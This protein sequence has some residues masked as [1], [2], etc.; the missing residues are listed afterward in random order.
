MAVI[1]HTTAR[2]PRNLA[3]RMGR[4]S[5]GHRKLAV[6]GWLAFV[7]AALVLGGAVGHEDP[8]RCG[9]AARRGRESG[10][11]LRR[12]GAR[13]RRLG[14][15]SRPEPDAARGRSDLRRH[16]SRRG[17]DDRS[18][19]GRGRP[20][21]PVCRGPRPHLRRR[22]F[23][24]DRLRPG[25]AA[26][27]PR[28][29]NQRRVDGR[30]RRPRGAQAPRL[31]RGR[32]RRSQRRPGDRGHERARL[33]PRGAALDPALARD[34]AVRI[35]RDRRS[36]RSG[37]ARADS[38]GGRGRAA[39]L[40][41]PHLAGRRRR[42]LR[43]PADRAGSGRGLLALLH[44]PRARG[45]RPRQGRGRGARSRRRDLGPGSPPLRPD[46]LDRHGRHVRDRQQGAHL[47]RGRRDARR[48][49]R[50]RRLP[51]GAAGA[52]L[53]ARRPDREG[54][55]A[56][57]GQATRPALA[58]H[59]SPGRPGAPPPARLRAGRRRTPGH[60]RR[61]GL[62]PAHEQRGRDGTSAGAEDRRHL[63]PDPAGLPRRRPPCLR[64]ARGSRCRGAAGAAGRRRARPA[65]TEDRRVAEP[66]HRERQRRPHGSP[67]SRSGSSAPEPIGAR[68]TR[69][70]FCARGSS[71]GPSGR[72]P[73]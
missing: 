4:W 30:R 2:G 48:R 64:R 1:S 14:E 54:P 27:S 70:S 66:G 9:R 33:P 38:G 36:I 52:A 72:F 45:A 34:P 16:G 26:R 40:P 37:A 44:P 5:A 24:P 49:D 41:E 51:D 32:V 23:R 59:G 21:L 47:G 53:A 12:G 7:A 3:A 71:P 56:T 18:P 55:P 25:R 61:P 63:R 11:A 68:S 62:R 29:A 43:D 15:R 19:A 67:R 35:R 42:Q 17:A 69:S 46:G 13:Q 60:A 39:R 58:G 10:E 20:A 22:A 57:P 73:V 31:L 28:P 8:E 65:G 6:L 50:G